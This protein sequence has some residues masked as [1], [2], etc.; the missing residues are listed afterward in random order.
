MKLGVLLVALLAVFLMAAATALAKGPTAARITGPG[1]SSPLLLNGIGESGDGSPMA[2]LTME[3]GFFPATF[4]ESPDPMLPGRPKAELG[5]RYQVIYTV[6]GPTDNAYI[7]QSLFP[8]AAGGPILYTAPNQSFFDSERT[9]GGWFRATARLK[10]ALVRA[11]L[12]NTA[13]AKGSAA[14]ESASSPQLAGASPSSGGGGLSIPQIGIAAL[15]AAFA[16]A[17]GGTVLVRRRRSRALARP[18]AS[19]R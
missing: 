3:G 1:L 5:P 18:T 4:G 13:P 15:A 11:G 2:V 12:P 17:L 7:H 19:R 9:H 10:A 16:T 6:P 14:K 8:Y